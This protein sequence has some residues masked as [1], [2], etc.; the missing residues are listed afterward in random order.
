MDDRGNKNVT[1]AGTG[2]IGSRRT[3]HASRRATPS[4]RPGVERPLTV[5][6]ANRACRLP[7]SQSPSDVSVARSSDADEN[8]ANPPSEEATSR[9]MARKTPIE[10]TCQKLSKPPSRRFGAPGVSLA[11][12]RL[13]AI[14]PEEDRVKGLT[15]AGHPLAAGP[16]DRR[17]RRAFMRDADTG[18]T[19]PSFYAGAHRFTSDEREGGGRRRRGV[20]PNRRR[21]PAD[22]RQVTP[23]GRRAPAQ[24]RDW[25]GRRAGPSRSTAPARSGS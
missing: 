24:L 15:V 7:N 11:G 16:R 4:A 9:A 25:R 8:D 3:P 17:R 6:A 12:S 22:V 10:T 5:A 1:G 13:R 19:M 14:R 21:R 23:R 2:T 20:S 18:L